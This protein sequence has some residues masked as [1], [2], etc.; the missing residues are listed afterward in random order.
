M[1]SLYSKLGIQYQQAYSGPYHDMSVAGN[2]YRLVM[3]V[4]QGNITGFGRPAICFGDNKSALRAFKKLHKG[5]NSTWYQCDREL[6]YIGQYLIEEGHMP[7]PFYTQV[8]DLTKSE[9]QLFGDL[10]KSYKQLVRKYEPIVTV[11]PDALDEFKKLHAGD[12]H[13]LI[14]RGR[15]RSRCSKRARL[16]VSMPLTGKRRDSSS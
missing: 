7:V 14:R 11:D 8:I 16:S 1:R 6:D 9:P 12:R 10:R 2:D 15:Y 13:A 5:C 3:S 4:N